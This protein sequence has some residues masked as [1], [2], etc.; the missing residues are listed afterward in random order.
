MMPE[1][2]SPAISF[3]TEKKIKFSLFQS[4]TIHNSIESVAKERGQQ[5]E[6]LIRTLV[7]RLPNENFICTLIPGNFQVRWKILRDYFNTNRITMASPDEVEQITGY[8][9]GTV[10]PFGLK[11]EIPII[12]DPKVFAFEEISLGSGIKSLAI[13]MGSND[14]NVLLPTAKILNLI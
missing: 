8:K 6:Q 7:F 4:L 5:P 13:I 3:L 2:S 9:I 12:I 10:S 14:L 1:N 11:S